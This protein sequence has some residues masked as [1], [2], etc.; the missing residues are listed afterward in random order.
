MAN[1]PKT[2]G[3]RFTL[4]MLATKLQHFN[5]TKTIVIIPNHI[6]TSLLNGQIVHSVNSSMRTE[7][8]AALKTIT[9]HIVTTSETTSKLP[10]PELLGNTRRSALLQ[11]IVTIR[12]TRTTTNSSYTV[13]TL[14]ERCFTRTS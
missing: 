2:N 4:S 11:R 1:T 3:A 7:P 13:Y 6:I 14:L 9:F 8:I 10:L 5:N 12:V